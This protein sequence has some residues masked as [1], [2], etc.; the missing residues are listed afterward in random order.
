VYLCVLYGSVKKQLL[1]A[2]ERGLRNV[3]WVKM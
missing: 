2:Y 3:T 1:F